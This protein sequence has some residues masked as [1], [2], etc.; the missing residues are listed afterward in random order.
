M[1]LFGRRSNVNTS[2]QRIS[3]FQV[4]QSS[5]G[6]PVK[7]VFGTAMISGVLGDFTDFTAHAKTTTTTSGGKGGGGV[8]QTDTTYT[9]SVAGVLVL[10]EGKLGGVGQVWSG[11]K[12]TDCYALNLQFFN[13]EKAQAP[14]GYML[15][16]HPDHALTYSGTSYLA[17]VVDLG[18]SA[19]LPNMNFEVYGLCQSTAPTMYL[20]KSYTKTG[21]HYDEVTIEGKELP[22]YTLNDTFSINDCDAVESVTSDNSSKIQFHYDVSV[23]NH[24]ATIHVYTESP[25]TGQPITQVVVTYKQGYQE[26]IGTPT[27]QKM[28]QYAYNKEIEISNFQSNRYVEEYVFDSASGTGSWVT[29]NS[30]YYAIEQSKDSAGNV[31]AGVYT[32]IFNF[33]ERD[34]GMDRVDPTFIRIYY[35]AIQA[36]VDYTPTDANPRDIIYTLLTSTVYG[37]NFP[38][39]LIDEESFGTYSAYCQNNSLLL[40]P[41]YDEQ[42]S[43]SDII[44]GL[45]ECTNSE[46]V[47]SQGKVKIIPYWDGLTPNYAI[48]DRNIINQTEDTL[49]IERTSQADTY[50]IVPLEYTSRVDQYNSGVVYATDEGDIELHGVRQA[51][52]YSHP[53]IMNQSLAQAVAQLILQK[54][55]YNRNKYTLKLGQ[56]FILL[57]PMDAVTLESDLAKLGLTTVRVVEIVESADDYTLEIT[58]E[59]NLSGVSTA[60][61]YA[62]QSADRATSETNAQPG[63]VNK[64][65]MFEAPAPLVTSATGYELWIYASGD[66]KWWGGCSVWMSVDG[67]SYRLVGEVKQPARQGVITNSLPVEATPDETN[68]LSVDLSVSRSTLVGAT[69]QE[70]DEYVTLCWIDG[71]NN[72]E[73]ISYQN[74]T[75]TGLYQYDLTYLRRGVYGSNI[76]THTANAQ[77][78]RCDT[79]IALKIPFSASEI[80]NTYYVKLCSFNV[81]GTVEQ[82]LAAVDP[83]TITLHGYNKKSVTESG[84]E[85]L[86]LGVTKTISYN[87]TYQ[88]APSPQATIINGYAGDVININNMTTTSFDVKFENA[89]TSI[90]EQTRTINYIV[91][92]V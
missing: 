34:D 36:S 72:G 42:T 16:N 17:G 28:Q 18:D 69:Q 70:A 67:N 31:K 6:C 8:T 86:T 76:M 62:T 22:L 77:F 46:Y 44:S 60:P 32:Y 68:T 91:Y 55:L 4:N 13:G 23:S 52:T 5:Y 65:I 47:F 80:G 1:G 35:T 88:S 7:L 87:H 89:N 57:E 38:D 71:A 66:N 73:F 90:E 3:S 10:G 51:G 39:V 54:Q 49:L 20:K 24:V 82:E 74:A 9:Y 15:T 43:C 37:E 29:L 53:E 79:G 40:S 85:T 41:V 59:D 26:P 58:F 92:G 56:E 25:S 11:N 75:L 21:L 81:F 27:N 50:N 83:Y 33:D 63:N 30:R 2:T 84:T 12:T 78:V 61:T 48:T 19:S 64:P 14:W 45:M